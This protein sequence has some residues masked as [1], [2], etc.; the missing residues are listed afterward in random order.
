MPSDGGTIGCYNNLGNQ[1][2]LRPNNKQVNG[3]AY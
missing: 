2:A 1:S 3:E